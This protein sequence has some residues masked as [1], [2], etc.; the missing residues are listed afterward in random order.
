MYDTQKSYIT[1]SHHQT[2]SKKRWRWKPHSDVDTLAHLWTQY[3]TTQYKIRSPGSGLHISWRQQLLSSFVRISEKN[4]RKQWVSTYFLLY[5][6]ILLL[7]SRLL[8]YIFFRL[9][10]SFSVQFSYSFSSFHFSWL[11][12]FIT[13]IP[14]KYFLKVAQSKMKPKNIRLYGMVDVDTHS[15]S[16]IDE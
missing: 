7:S 8:S 9:R 11:R 3:Y 2:R 5:F 12:T 15:P 6:V 16:H 4:K 10:A 13:R 1:P 14:K